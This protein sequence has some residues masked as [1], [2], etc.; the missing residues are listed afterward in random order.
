[1]LS[2]FSRVRLFATQWAIAHKASLSMGFPRQEYWSRLPCP[3]L[4]DRPD[5]RIEPASPKAPALQADSLQLSH[6]GSPLFDIHNNKLLNSN[7]HFQIYKDFSHILTH[8]ILKATVCGKANTRISLFYGI[9][10]SVD[11][12]MEKL[13]YR[14][15]SLYMHSLPGTRHWILPATFWGRW[16]LDA[17]VINKETEAQTD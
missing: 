6:W 4:G 5:P 9:V 2:H 15:L 12:F 8:L 13:L 16:Q 1:M 7:D 14:Q 17:S 10:D 11:N 3:P